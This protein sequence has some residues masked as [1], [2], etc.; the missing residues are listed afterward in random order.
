MGKA[1]KQLMALLLVL[2]MV[3]T[4]VSAQAAE[5]NI[6]LHKVYTLE[7]G[8]EKSTYFEVFTIE[9]S[10]NVTIDMSVK[11]LSGKGANV[12]VSVMKLD[13]IRDSDDLG[14][15]AFAE[16]GL[17][18]GYSIKGKEVY[19]EA[20]TYVFGVKL[21]DWMI[22][23]PNGEPVSSGEK[24]EFSIKINGKGTL[25]ELDELPY[26]G[27]GVKEPEKPTIDGVPIVHE[28]KA[29][30]VNTKKDLDKELFYYDVYFDSTYNELVMK[31]T[32]DKAGALMVNLEDYHSDYLSLK[33]ALYKDA[34]CTEQIGYSTYRYSDETGWA[35]P[36]DIPKAGEYF[37]KFEVSKRYDGPDTLYFPVILLLV[38]GNKTAKVGVDY[39]AYQDYNSGKIRFKLKVEKAGNIT[40]NIKPEN[41]R[42]VTA[43][44]TLL[45]SK[46]KA[47]TEKQFRYVTNKDENLQFTYSVDKGTY[48]I[49]V[50][51]SVGA[52]I[53]NWNFKEVKD[54]SGASK[55]KATN[56]K[57]GG[58]A[59]KGIITPTDKTSKVDWFKFKVTASKKIKITLNYDTA[60]E[61]RVEI[62]DSKGKVLTGGDITLYAGKDTLT[63]A[64][65]KLPK[66][67]YYIKISKP[68]SKGSGYYTI[69]VK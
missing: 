19:L 15:V 63:L 60:G 32:I 35:I 53:A 68:N 20:D 61:I 45:N 49:E 31:V 42:Y 40:F 48:Y 21:L 16:K 2:T 29:N 34:D 69:K 30:Y 64:T 51:T 41:A 8:S 22:T 50:D 11:D 56:L 18:D 26:G 12:L 7:A 13:Y 37:M 24:V 62:C 57:I 59:V 5:G 25:G 65:S 36:I 38:Q 58:K 23:Y 55:S 17:S 6:I 10:G 44:T 1:I 46:K 39:I 28:F 43:H 33:A 54:K 52:Y 67:T 3:I 27:V 9:E 47:I 4:P 66:S 14:K